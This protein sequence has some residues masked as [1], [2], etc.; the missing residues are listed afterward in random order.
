[1]PFSFANPWELMPKISLEH[2]Q[3]RRGQILAAASRCFNLRGY[4]ATSMEDVAREATLSIGALYTYFASKE[5]LFGALAEA[6]FEIMKAQ[7][8][9]LVTGEGSA[10]GRLLRGIDDF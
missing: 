10:M 2:E 7:L 4:R 5:D 3:M 8:T 9:G 6:R 1:P